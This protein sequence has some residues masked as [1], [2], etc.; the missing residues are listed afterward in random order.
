MR[1][2]HIQPTE[3]ARREAVRTVSGA[4]AIEQ[5]GIN[6]DIIITFIV[7]A[8][9]VFAAV[10]AWACCVAAGNAGRIGE[11]WNDEQETETSA[12]KARQKE[13]EKS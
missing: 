6:M 11:G 13:S 9:M 5:G 8:I 4:G 2:V 12:G 10:T 3:L 1:L 7:T